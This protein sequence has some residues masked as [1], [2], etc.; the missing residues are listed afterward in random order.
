LG[1][2][3]LAALLRLELRVGS[4]VHVV[5]ALQL[6]L[7]D[8]LLCQLLKLWLLLGILVFVLA[9]LLLYALS[10]LLARLYGLGDRVETVLV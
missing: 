8:R 3:V 7:V 2:L 10:V 4:L 1:S 5:V 6:M 9:A